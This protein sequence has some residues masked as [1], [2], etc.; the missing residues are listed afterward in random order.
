[1]LR[2][3]LAVCPRSGV[4]SLTE[5]AVG[6]I[7]YFAG[8]VD[9]ILVT[10]EE[11][12]LDLINNE[13]EEGGYS[14]AEQLATSTSKFHR[15]TE[16][17]I[18]PTSPLIG[19]TIRQARLREQF[20]VAVVGFQR[21]VH[22]RRDGKINDVVI[23]A[24]DILL[25]DEGAA[26]YTGSKHFRDTFTKVNLVRESQTRFFMTPYRVT[27]SSSF[28]ASAPPSARIAPLVECGRSTWA[29]ACERC[30]LC[31]CADP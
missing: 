4:G 30:A 31:L 10:A 7:L 8:E 12:G 22:V 26:A 28:L 15:L 29:K 13:N 11:L 24:G 19:Q 14:V 18:P 21:H 6:D 23:V 17:T 20:D 9:T 1:M 16:V 5:L 25:F 27:V 2:S 3:L